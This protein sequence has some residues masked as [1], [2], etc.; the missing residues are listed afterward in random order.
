MNIKISFEL[1]GDEEKILNIIKILN[2]PRPFSFMPAPS[3]ISP[4]TICPTPNCGGSVGGLIG[5]LPHLAPSCPNISR[6][7]KDWK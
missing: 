7:P 4:L 6:D 1:E 2:G 3:E 5:P